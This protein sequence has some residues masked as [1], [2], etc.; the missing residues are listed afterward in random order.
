[1]IFLDL[2]GVFCDLHSRLAEI[3][4][5]SMSDL[6]PGEWYLEKSWGVSGH[7]LWNHPEV[8]ALDFWSTLWKTP[9]ADDLMALITEYYPIEDQCFLTKALPNDP[10]CVRGKALWLERHY[11]KHAYFIGN[12]SKKFNAGADKILLDDAD[13]NIAAFINHGGEGILFPR[14]WNAHYHL[15][16]APLAYVEERLAEKF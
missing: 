16:V 3:H 5:K 9:W 4:G 15:E 6:I 10:E 11:P 14:V 12:G 7:D 1:M 13:H 8:K 2:D